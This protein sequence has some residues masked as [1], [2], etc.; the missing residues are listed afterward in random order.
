MKT[1]YSV[2]QA[3]SQLPKLL[4]EV[5]ETASAYGIRVHD[6]VKGYLIG[7]E[8]MEAIL[9]TLEILA[10]KT[11]GRAIRDYEA[12]KGKFFDLDALDE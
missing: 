10:N 7:R 3:Q 12:G 8:R 11:A 4:K 1:T 6:E 5:N 9:E 2:T